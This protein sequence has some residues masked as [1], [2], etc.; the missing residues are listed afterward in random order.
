MNIA[1]LRGNRW[2]AKSER[3]PKSKQE[4]QKVAG[5]GISDSIFGFVSDFESRISDFL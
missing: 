1:P 3:N 4:K 5:F 2:K